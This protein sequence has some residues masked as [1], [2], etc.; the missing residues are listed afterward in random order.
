MTKVSELNSGY[1]YDV[2]EISRSLH[3]GQTRWFTNEPYYRHPARVAENVRIV[4]GSDDVIAAAYLHDVIED[5]EVTAHQLVDI[6]VKPS[7][8]EI[9]AKLTRRKNE[10]YFEY[11][12]RQC[13][14][15]ETWY[16]KRADVI[17]N[18]STVPHGHSLWNKYTEALVTL[19]SGG[20]DLRGGTVR[21]NIIL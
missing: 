9:V 4:G 15:I 1:L 17:D 14:T 7:T 5:C 20:R 18:L 2:F 21:G 19:N 13:E 11:V 8:V 10:P 16:I 6:G 12:R 3:K